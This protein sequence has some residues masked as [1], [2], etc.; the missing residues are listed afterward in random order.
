MRTIILITIT[1]FL[2]SF[3]IS[4]KDNH[5]P[6]KDIMHPEV[7]NH[8]YMSDICKELQDK[9]QTNKDKAK[10][11]QIRMHDNENRILKETVNTLQGIHADLEK[12]TTERYDNLLKQ[13][14]KMQKEIEE[15]KAR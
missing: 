15:N 9:V 1:S 12:R 5:M 14:E 13:I 3:L 4:C 8:F 10:Q 11:D 2:L 6:I 7:N